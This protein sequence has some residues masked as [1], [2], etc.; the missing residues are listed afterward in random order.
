M[1][2]VFSRI[3]ENILNKTI[4]SPSYV[5]SERLFSDRVKMVLNH[6]KDDIDICF[7][8]KANSYLLSILPEEFTRVEVCS[9]GELEICKSLSIPPEKIIFSG[10]NKTKE[11]VYKALDYGVFSGIVTAESK[12]HLDHIKAYCQEK[13][14][15]LPADFKVPV[16]LRLSDESQFGIDPAELMEIISKAE[17]YP[18]VK[19]IGLHYFTGTG[20]KKSKQIEKE[21]NRLSSLVE[22]LRKDYSFTVEFIEYGPGLGVEYFTESLEDSEENE[23]A[24]WKE[25]ADLING[26]SDSLPNVKVSIEMGRFFAASTGVY[27]TRIADTKQNDGINYLILDGGL[28]QLKYDGQMQG[29]QKPY[30]THI[31]AQSESQKGKEDEGYTLCGSLCT[32]ADILARDVR[33]SN[34]SLGDFLLFHK[35]GAYS[36]SEGMAL[37]LTRDL[38]TV[39]ILNANNELIRCRDSIETVEFNGI[40]G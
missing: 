3:Q 17:D 11:D 30:I 5:F 26:F 33:L 7:S 29:M 16:I 14:A 37:F 22:T 12:L 9:P 18:G 40:R 31:K 36:V 32:T 10:V 4:Q 28:H 8:I 38:P 13:K 34:P 6:L 25:V 2:E 21:L 39:Y 24:L 19:I 15:V 1:K 20:K 23:V 27:I 35:T